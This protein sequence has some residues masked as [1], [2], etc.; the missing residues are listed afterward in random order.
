MEKSNGITRRTFVSV[1]AAMTAMAA[2]ASA[3]C[4]STQ[5]SVEEGG[6]ATSLAGDGWVSAACWHNCGGRCVNKALVQDGVVIRQKTDDSHE[7]TYEQFQQRA[8]VRGRSQREQVFSADRV[9]KPLKRSGWAPGGGSN[10]QEEL[11]GKDTWEEIEW[12]EALDLIAQELDR[13]AIEY[14]NRSILCMG[15]DI[16]T[17]LSAYGGYVTRWGTISLGSWAFTSGPIGFF[18]SALSDT[19]NDRLDFQN[20][21][22]IVLIGS[23]PAWSSAGSPIYHAIMNKEK[24][25]KFIGIDPSYNESY[26]AVDAEWVPC[27]PGCD[28]ALCIGLAYEMLR[29]DDGK[30]L[31]DWDFLDIHTLGF[32]ADHMPEG[33]DASGNFK[34]Y[35][36]GTYD[37]VPKDPAWASKPRCIWPWMR[38]VCRSKCLLQQVPGLTAPTAID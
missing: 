34:D 25:V 31:I 10:A 37:G 8:C 22:T 21:E 13:V 23:N 29:M 17:L 35:L 7:D 26:A 12:G 16:A 6:G 38:L 24:G 20:C 9:R 14:D 3:S 33:E 4:S 5:N 19:A 15:E 32:D 18:G 2:L 30:Q 36:L 27:Y 1:A 28:T 11:C